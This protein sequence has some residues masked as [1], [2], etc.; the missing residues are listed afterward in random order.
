QVLSCWY[1]LTEP[2]RT[3]VQQALQA[4]QPKVKSENVSEPLNGMLS[5]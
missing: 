5:V 3:Q 4:L 1:T 2:Q